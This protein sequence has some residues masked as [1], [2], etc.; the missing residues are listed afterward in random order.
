MDSGDFRLGEAQGSGA[1]L[2]CTM[3]PA[4]PLQEKNWEG[5]VLWVIVNLRITH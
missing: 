2:A 4:L 3:T 1:Y 5:A